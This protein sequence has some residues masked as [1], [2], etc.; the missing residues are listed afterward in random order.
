[1]TDIVAER[2]ALFLGSRLKRLA[3]TMQA[4]VAR[5]VEAA[6]L[7][8]QPSHMPLLGTLDRDGPRTIGSLTETMRLAQPTVTRAVTRLAELGLVEVNREH[9]DQRQKTVRL[10]EA[11]RAALARAK[12]LVWNRT[13]AAVEEVL[14]TLGSPFL[15]Q[16]TALE[17]MLAREPLDARALRRQEAGV[18]IQAYSDD[19]AGAFKSINV[20]WISDMYAVEPADLKV[21]DHPREAII[22]AGGA[23]LFAVVDGVGPVGTC[24]L[25]RTGERTFELTKM[26]VLKAARGARIGERL[27][28]ATIDE[29][30][31]LGAERLY[32]LSNKQSVAAIRLYEKHGFVHDAEIMAAYGS[33]YERCDVAMLYRPNAVAAPPRSAN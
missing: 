1:M 2:S 16:L 24:A 26:G 32:L 7:P 31:R 15:D 22:D 19:L 10:T 5:L 11:G 25:R 30:A 14:E 33:G 13:E 12:I 4:Q 20:E 21:L 17:E 8:L 23:I 9:R 6:E 29:A 3:E 28:T 27:L 18:S